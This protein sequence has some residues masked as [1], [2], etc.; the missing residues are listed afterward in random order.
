MLVL[1][2]LLVFQSRKNAFS[3]NAGGPRRGLRPRGGRGRRAEPRR[4]AAVV[5]VVGVAAC[6]RRLVLVDRGA[7][8]GAAMRYEVGRS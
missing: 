6:R 4:G 1:H 8:G 7:A 3:K 2:E 5:G